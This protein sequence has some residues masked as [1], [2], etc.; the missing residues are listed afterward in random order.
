M[1]EPVKNSRYYSNVCGHRYWFYTGRTLNKTGY[2]DYG[3]VKR[4]RF[5]DYDGHVEDFTI[6]EF[7]KYFE[8]KCSWMSE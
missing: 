6:E 8:D 5:E 3:K 7:S 1:N 4:Y 2:P